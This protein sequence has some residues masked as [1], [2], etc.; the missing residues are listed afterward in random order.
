MFTKK[1]FINSSDVDEYR[2]LKP[3][4]FFKLFQDIAVEAV[5]QTGYGKQFTDEHNLMWVI[6]RVNVEIKRMPIYQETVLC[7]TYPGPTVRFFYPRHFFVKSLD[8]E[9]LIKMST[10][11]AILDAKTRSI[12]NI[13]PNLL[14]LDICKSDIE[15]PSPRKIMPTADEYYMSRLVRYSDCD[16]NL[17]L[18][19]TRY[20][21][22]IFD[23][24]DSKF[25]KTHHLA[26]IQIDYVSEVKEN[27]LI[28]LY[29]NHSSPSQVVGKVVDKVVFVA[30]MT[31]K[32]N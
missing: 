22:Y 26:S 21:D 15:L 24:H 16:L 11:W 13:D 12:A 20:V 9:V 14:K 27:E 25:Y 8:G 29:I 17:H 1:V 19:N 31:F 5:E 4:S 18:N 23:T 32:E 28:D 6:T 10:T 7:E 3:S 2:N 30:Q